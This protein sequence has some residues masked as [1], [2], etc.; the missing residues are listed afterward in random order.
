MKK[1]IFYQVLISLLL[2]SCSTNKVKND[3]EKE[4][5][6]GQVKSIY[7]LVSQPSENGQIFNEIINGTLE[8]YNMDGYI[9]KSTRYIFFDN[10]CIGTEVTNYRYEDGLL[11]EEILP[12]KSRWLYKYD[13]NNI[14]TEK[15]YYDSDGY[16]GTKRTYK[17]DK[18]GN[19]SSETWSNNNGNLT[20][21]I[22][23]IYDKNGN[24]TSQAISYSKFSEFYNN[25]PIINTEKT[26]DENN[27]LIHEKTTYYADNSKKIIKSITETSNIYDD[28]YQ[29]ETV[30][31]IEKQDSSE[32]VTE[33]YKYKYAYD[34]HGN[35]IETTRKQMKG[36][37]LISKIYNSVIYN[38]KEINYYNSDEPEKTR[39]SSVIANITSP[40]KISSNFYKYLLLG[41]TP[42]QIEEKN[43]KLGTP[44][45]GLEE[46]ERYSTIMPELNIVK[47]KWMLRY[48]SVEWG[49]QLHNLNYESLIYCFLR[50]NSPCN[51]CIITP[52]SSEVSYQI[53]DE[54]NKNFTKVENTKTD[55]YNWIRNDGMKV[56]LLNKGMAT[57]VFHY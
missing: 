53:I 18:S 15:I 8:E 1:I 22:D 56:T 30:T 16:P 57:F 29:N 52:S 37:S 47:S 11:K 46:I 13:K 4:G 17:Y 45:N 42:K 33:S 43:E 31:K 54:L 24:N 23:Y 38:Q 20:C 55:E 12:G 32:I 51:C 5:L 48:N 27:K 39:L 26:Y 9:E 3:L 40:E 41:F 35:C 10:E 50:E 28:T 34:S 14:S 2:V 25:T 6:K 19:L 44:R 7:T 21:S 49:I 36:D